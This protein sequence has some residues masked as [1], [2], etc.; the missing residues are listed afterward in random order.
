MR[1]TRPTVL[2]LALAVSALAIVAAGCGGGG[3]DTTGGGGEGGG[4]TITVGSDVP[5]PRFEEFGQSKTEFKG[6]DVELV[7]AIGAKIGRT[8]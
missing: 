1:R 8:P 6:F 4:E 7:E 3:N 5:Y 2:I